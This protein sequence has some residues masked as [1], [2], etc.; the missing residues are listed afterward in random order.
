MPSPRTCQTQG[1]DRPVGLEG[2]RQGHHAERSGEAPLQLQ[3]L[4]T[5]V[6]PEPF[7]QRDA[8]GVRD[9]V[10][11]QQQRRQ[12]GVARQHVPQGLGPLWPDAVFL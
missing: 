9:R 5:A 12:G 2:G 6:V 3:R 11:T 1:S 4:E 7:R 8:S 10:A